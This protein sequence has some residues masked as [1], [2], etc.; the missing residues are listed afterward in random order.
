MKIPE[1]KNLYTTNKDRMFHVK[2][3][4]DWGTLGKI[5]NVDKEAYHSFLEETVGNITGKQIAVRAP[6]TE[7][8][9]YTVENGELLWSDEIKQSY[10]DLFDNDLVCTNVSEEH[11]GLALPNVVSTIINEMLFQADPGFATVPLLQNGV[12]EMIEEFGS[13]DIKKNYLEK[14]IKKGYTGC[15]DLTEPEAGSDLG[16]I[17]TKATEIDGDTYITGSKMFI[18]NGGANIHLVLAREG[19]NYKETLGQ[20]KGLSLYVVPKTIN[21]KFNN[22]KVTKLE[23]KLGIHSSPTCEVTFEEA[24]GKGAK[25][26]LLGEKGKGLK[27]MLKLMNNARLGVAAQA[28]GIIEASLADAKSYAIERK[29]FG[30]EIANYGLVK[31][32]LKDMQVY[33]E[34]I[35]SVVYSA[36]FATDMEKGLKKNGGD[37]EELRRYSNHAA[38]LVPLIKYYAAEKAVELTK[39]GLQ[40]HGGVGYTKEFSAEKHLRDAVITTIY[41]GT[42]EIQ[43]SLFI[44]EA[45]TGKLTGQ[46]RANLVPFLEDID[47]GLEHLTTNHWLAPDAKKVKAANSHVKESLDTLAT[48]IMQ[49]LE[50]NPPYGDTNGVSTQAKRL[51]EMTVEVYA[52]YKLLE[53]AWKSDYKKTVA[54]V[55]IQDML[56]RVEMYSAQIK[57][58]STDTLKD[59]DTIIGRT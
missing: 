51:A 22:V 28:L 48:Y 25:G 29:Q 40:V 2:E 23:E 20:T 19:D 55:F 21:G 15:M 9:N 30:T 1:G 33:S 10:R 13:E 26:F 41:E 34:V 3:I 42:S 43:A 5:K 6:K 44:K 54:K 53:Q 14:M 11:G 39:K 36:A 18:T 58:L 7:N 46:S 4:I 24:D 45:L 32:L 38:I 52:S 8:N 59:Y 27:Y 17:R 16:G 35:R 47:K 12:A 57:N 56:P 50:K 31:D 49:T 37:E